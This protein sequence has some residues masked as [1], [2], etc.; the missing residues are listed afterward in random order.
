M[1]AKTQSQRRETLNI[2][3]KSDERGLI[4][5]AALVRGQN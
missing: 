2:R 4:D 5:R 3:I 1:A